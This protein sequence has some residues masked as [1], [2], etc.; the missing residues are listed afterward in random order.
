MNTKGLTLLELIVVLIIVL[1]A[2]V[3]ALPAF[4]MY[5]INSN[6]RSATRELASDFASLKGRALAENRMCQIT[7][8]VPQNS[9][10][11]E[12][13]TNEGSPCGGW[14]AFQAEQPVKNL[15]TYGSDIVFDA[16]QTSTSTY[17]LQ[18][19]GTVSEG[20]IVMQNSRRSTATININPTGRTIVS[21]SMQ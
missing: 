13:C 15:S 8:N 4:Q 5:S 18:T 12:Q 21:F 16:A 1:T 11:L 20:T 2:S 10:T 9:Y 7:L 19:R 17:I 14:N 6:L 3:I